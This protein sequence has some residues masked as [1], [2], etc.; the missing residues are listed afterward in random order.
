[1]SELSDIWLRHVRIRCSACG[2]ARSPRF[3]ALVRGLRA[4]GTRM[5]CP[6]C[7][8]LHLTLVG[9]GRLFCHACDDVRP[10]RLAAR[11]PGKYS[12]ECGVCADVKA[13]LLPPGPARPAD[14][15]GGLRRAG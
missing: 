2:Q 3:S 7:L 12:L 14:L 4:L 9:G 8:H 15:G 1:M 5:E 11:A 10:G 13:R 6:V